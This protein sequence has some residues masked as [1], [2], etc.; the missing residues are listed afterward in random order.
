M[1]RTEKSLERR[2]IGRAME[3]RH[4]SC[5]FLLC[6][7]YI[8]HGISRVRYSSIPQQVSRFGRFLNFPSA[9]SAHLLVINFKP[10]IFVSNHGSVCNRQN[11]HAHAEVSSL[12]KSVRFNN[13]Q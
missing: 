9:D 4:I 10:S 13:S 5:R 1:E 2:L 3:T 6:F 11:Q 7:S 12:I 8:F